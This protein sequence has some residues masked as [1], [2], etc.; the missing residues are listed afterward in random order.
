MAP[1]AAEALKLTAKDLLEMGIIDEIIKEPLGG[2]H[3]DPETCAE[4]VKVAIKK[5]LQQLLP[6]S[7]K[8]LLENRYKRF[9]K[10]GVF[11]EGK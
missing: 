7:K 5:Y 11:K 3:R 2:A 4:N 6:L 10:I 1:E 8:E 9:R